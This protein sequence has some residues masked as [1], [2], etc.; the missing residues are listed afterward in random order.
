MFAGIDKLNCHMCRVHIKNP[1][2]KEYYMKDWLI[3]NNCIRVFS[4]KKQSEVGMLHSELCIES[5]PCSDFPP[6]LKPNIDRIVEENY[7]VHV[8]LS[9]FL[10]NGEIAWNILYL[11][12]ID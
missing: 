11:N 2:H 9:K 7:F 5:K 8:P 4:R 12:L 6:K 10:S 3:R 1:S